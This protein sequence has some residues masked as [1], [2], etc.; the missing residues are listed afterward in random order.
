MTMDLSRKLN[1]LYFAQGCC[2]LAVTVDVYLVSMLM[3]IIK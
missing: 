3:H 2:V 1:F